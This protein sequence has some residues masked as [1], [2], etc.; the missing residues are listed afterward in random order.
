M[1]KSFH[2]FFLFTLVAF[3][4]TMANAETAEL[5]TDPNTGDKFINE[6]QGIPA[7]YDYRT[8]HAALFGGCA[9]YIENKMSVMEQIRNFVEGTGR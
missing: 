4:A 7:F 3:F 8:V 9:G 6:L 5:Q 2:V 1:K